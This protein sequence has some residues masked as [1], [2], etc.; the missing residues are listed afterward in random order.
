MSVNSKQKG[1]RYEREIHV[2]KLDD[3][4]D[5]GNDGFGST[6]R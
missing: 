3:N 1:A 2:K 4:T 6:G 5:R